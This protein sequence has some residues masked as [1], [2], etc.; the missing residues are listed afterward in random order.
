MVKSFHIY[1]ALLHM[2]KK[3]F[4]FTVPY[5]IFRFRGAKNALCS[6]IH[7]DLS[8]EFNTYGDVQDALNAKWVV[9]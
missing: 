7:S 1:G 2:W 3:V 8:L 5:Y 9:F 4:T 6:Y